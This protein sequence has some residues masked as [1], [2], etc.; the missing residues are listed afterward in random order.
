MAAKILIVDDEPDLELL[1][2]QRFRHA[3]R[4]GA[5]EFTFARDGAEALAAVATDAG[6]DLVLTDIKMPVM[7][8]LTFLAR[9]R[10]ARPLLGAVVVSAYGDMANIRAAMNLGAL[11]FL[12]KPID[13]GDFETTVAKTL[14]QV[15]ERREA[16]RDRER[17]LLVERDLETAAE[18]Q[19]AFLPGPAPA[20]A[21]RP[22]CALHAAMVPARAVGGD[23]YDYFPLDDRRLA[24]VVG[25]VAGKGVPAALLMVVARTLLRATAPREPNPAACLAA[26][27]GQLVRDSPSGLFV[28]VFYGVL[29]ADTGEL[30][31]STGGHPPAYVLRGGGRVEPAEGR[32]LLVGALREAVYHP[33]RLRLAP[34]DGLFL[35]TD[36]VTEA[37]NDRGELFAR[38]R[39]EDA[40]G[41]LAAAGPGPLVRGVL[42]EVRDFVGAAPPADD[43]TALALRYR[44]A[45]AARPAGAPPRRRPPAAA[46]SSPTTGPATGRCSASTSP[47]WVTAPPPPRTAGRFWRCCGPSPST[48][49][50]STSSC[51]SWT[52]TRCWSGSRPTSG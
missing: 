43:L 24:L 19:R 6:L 51:R 48:W 31:Y 11:D 20:A 29:H 41:R 15:R 40:L 10:D 49:C 37:K 13:F 38:E 33:R 46:S 50:C 21:G 23:F 47:S 28:T 45:A 39:L 2:R 32:G 17:L 7:D 5:Y 22:E 16:A 30:L 18:I 1:I 27:N 4:E 34:G 35:Y 9:L 42:D 8:G 25:D 52:A 36:G 26:V 12:T 3:I 14:R 44:G